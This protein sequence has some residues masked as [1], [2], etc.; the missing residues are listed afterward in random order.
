MSTD[1]PRAENSRS[2]EAAGV[3]EDVI[4]GQ[5]IADATF[6][7]DEVLYEDQV[8]P[9]HG[10]LGFTLR[11]LIIGGLWALAF[12]TSFFPVYRASDASIWAN[13]IS[14]IIPIGLPTVAVFLIVLR[15]LS[16]QGIRRV[17]SL[18]IDQFASVVFSFAAL[19]WAQF[20]WDV[21]AVSI[22][23][24]TVLPLWVNWVQLVLML[25]LVAVT[26]FAPL[27]PALR[28]DFRGRLATLAHRN[29]NPVRPVVARPKVVPAEG[30]SSGDSSASDAAPDSA[31]AN[32]D[33]DVAVTTSPAAF[34]VELSDEH[35]TD[36]ISRAD[37]A[38]HMPL[39]AHASGGDTG[40]QAASEQDEYVPTYSRRS[41]SAEAEQETSAEQGA[42]AAD[43]GASTATEAL[44]GDVD[45]EQSVA[46]VAVADEVDPLPAAVGSSDDDD[47]D[48]SQETAARDAVSAGANGAD[49]ADVVHD[50]DS[51][52]GSAIADEAAPEPRVSETAETEVLN[53]VSSLAELF[54]TG[55][56]AVGSPDDKELSAVERDVD[57]T[58]PR[59]E[60]T[61]S[62]PFWA[63]APT[64]RDVMDERG[65]PLFRIGPTAWA[66]V[67]E[68]RGGAFVVRHDDGRIGY[69]HD[70]SDITKG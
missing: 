25:G 43:D 29:A 11:E 65:N 30:A 69:L 16:P 58:K 54:E 55:P 44:A 14:W 32:G 15:R 52:P 34:D 66:L 24:R 67:L 21:V 7:E 53:S 26:V 68:D 13:G 4:D 48:G 38:A 57:S 47:V 27:I 40:T 56:I 39:T 36:Q 22:A 20:S 10:I 70:I 42:D 63:L 37:L 18:G 2:D 3:D 61:T 5:L 33:A 51:A 23:T 31:E 1:Y 6:D 64:E 59:T 49:S 9:E 12:V 28:E 17:G 8:K 60:Q 35:T 45:E 41:R 46:D 50:A 62:Q 19:S